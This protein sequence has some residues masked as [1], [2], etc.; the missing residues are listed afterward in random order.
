MFYCQINP[1]HCFNNHIFSFLAE[2][3]WYLSASGNN[4]DTC[5]TTQATPCQTL[6]WLLGRF[7]DT[8]P[9]LNE[10]LWI[11]TDTSLLIDSKLVVSSLI[12]LDN[13]SNLSVKL[14]YQTIGKLIYNFTIY[15]FHLPNWHWTSTEKVLHA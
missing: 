1:K 12:F 10:T 13:P 5:G 7:Y 15:F 14:L 9:M 2:T 11:V 8:S 6:D 4:T 3:Y